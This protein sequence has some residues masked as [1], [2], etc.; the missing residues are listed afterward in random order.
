MMHADSA[1]RTGLIA[2]AVPLTRLLKPEEQF[3]QIERL[4][5]NACVE[6]PLRLKALEAI[7]T[8]TDLIPDTTECLAWLK[9]MNQEIYLLRLAQE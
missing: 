4:Y 1:I 7:S 9:K 3:A 6:E 2:Q 8:L 5:E